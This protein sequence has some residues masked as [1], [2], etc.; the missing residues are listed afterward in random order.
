MA[1]SLCCL[2]FW[3]APSGQPSATAA[4]VGRN[5]LEEAGFKTPT[6]VLRNVLQNNVLHNNTHGQQAGQELVRRLE[7][8][9]SKQCVVSVQL[10]R[11]CCALLSYL[12]QLQPLCASHS[13]LQSIDK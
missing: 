4:A 3:L 11:W 9:A 8:A 1:M 10:V 7:A 12:A 13:V 6:A 2:G 5:L